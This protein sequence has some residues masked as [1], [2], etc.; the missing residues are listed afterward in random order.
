[1][2]GIWVVLWS[3]GNRGLKLTSIERVFNSL[4]YISC[5]DVL[6]MW[7]WIYLYKKAKQIH[8]P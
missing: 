7:A 4:R 3:Y 1:V 6:N 2:A 5:A 8:P